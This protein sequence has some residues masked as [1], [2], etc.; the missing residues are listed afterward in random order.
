MSQVAAGGVDEAFV[1]VDALRLGNGVTVLGEA[2]NVDGLCGGYNL[3]FAAA[4]ALYVFAQSERA[5]LS[6]V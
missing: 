6:L 2:L 1:D 4:S 5:K 3:Y